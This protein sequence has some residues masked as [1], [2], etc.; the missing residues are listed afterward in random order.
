FAAAVSVVLAARCK[1][2]RE[3]TFP[4][5]LLATAAAIHSVHRPWWNYYYLHFAIPIA[6]LAGY[7]LNEGIQTLLRLFSPPSVAPKSHGGGSTLNSKAINRPRPLG[8]TYQP[9]TLIPS[10]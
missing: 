7:A 9:S 8:L 2:L 5:T 10:G 1:R 3:I 4:L 6:W